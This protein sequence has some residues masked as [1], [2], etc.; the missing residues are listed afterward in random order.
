MALTSGGDGSPVAVDLVAGLTYP[1]VKLAT[2]DAG[3]VTPVTSTN[4]VPTDARIS[5]S[6]TAA[7]LGLVANVTGYGNLRVTT[8]PG[9]LFSDPMDGV[10]IDTTSRWNAPVVVSGMTVTQATGGQIITTNTTNSASAFIDSA[11]PRTLV[12]PRYDAFP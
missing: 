3:T 1:I 2:G 4:R 9:S 12:E 6:A 10:T 8:E 11:R 7:A 5:S